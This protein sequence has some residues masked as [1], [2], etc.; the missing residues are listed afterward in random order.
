MLVMYVKFRLFSRKNII[1][2]S[3][4]RN[5]ASNSNYDYYSLADKSHNRV[6]TDRFIG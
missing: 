6:N 4:S 2:S 3:D 1:V 5:L